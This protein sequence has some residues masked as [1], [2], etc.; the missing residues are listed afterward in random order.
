MILPQ[1]LADLRRDEGERLSVYQDSLGYWTIG[2][3][4]CVDARVGGALFPEES[5]FI[6]QNRVARIA[7][8]LSATYPWFSG[9]NDA[10]QRALANMRFQL[11]QGGFAA[12]TR[13]H[14][15]CARQDWPDA[16]A[17]VLSSLYARQVPARAKR[18]ADALFYG[19]DHE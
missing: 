10:R 17:E 11:G 3:G 16:S 13:L 7:T 14:A 15:A 5:A 9:I 4:I 19:V 6:L 8:E 2:V 12:F 1:L 18:L